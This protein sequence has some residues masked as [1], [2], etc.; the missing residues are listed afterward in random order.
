MIPPDIQAT[1]EDIRSRRAQ[2]QFPHADT[3]RKVIEKFY[4]EELKAK[5]LYLPI[6]PVCGILFGIVDSLFEAEPS[7]QRGILPPLPNLDAAPNVS[8]LATELQEVKLKLSAIVESRR[9]FATGCVDM[10]VA[11]SEWLPSGGVRWWEDFA[12][13][14]PSTSNT[15]TVSL[16]ESIDGV[17][18]LIGRLANIFGNSPTRE[19]EVFAQ[20]RQ[21]YRAGRRNAS[22]RALTAAELKEGKVVYP[23]QFEGTPREAVDIYLGGTP[24]KR[25]FECRIPFSL[26]DKLRSEHGVIVAGTGGGKTSLLANLVLEDL[27]KS[28]SRKLLSRM[29]RL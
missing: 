20:L 11:F 6:A 2:V 22:S 13:E 24:L 16:L 14:I 21:A 18:N 28:R 23:Y 26:P 8:V 10:L 5:G 19:R 1:F 7:F 4:L 9:A 29:N 15:L 3:V 27:L 12:A 17:P 25:F